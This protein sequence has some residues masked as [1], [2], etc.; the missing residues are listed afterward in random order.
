MY[1]HNAYMAY[2]HP[3]IK[4]LTR[5][6][7]MW[8]LEKERQRSK[9]AVWEKEKIRKA[10]PEVLEH[11][12]WL[13]SIAHMVHY[14]KG[15]HSQLCQECQNWHAQTRLTIGLLEINE[16]T[17]PVGAKLRVFDVKKLCPYTWVANAFTH[18][19]LTSIVHWYLKQ[20]LA[21]K[22]SPVL[23]T[24]FSLLNRWERT[25]PSPAVPAPFTRVVGGEKSRIRWGFT[26][27]KMSTGLQP[28]SMLS[29]YL[30]S[31][32]L[33]GKRHYCFAT[34]RVIYGISSQFLFKNSCG[35]NEFKITLR[36]RHI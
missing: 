11:Q 17:A 25:D 36:F 19:L 9:N 21:R 2:I 27:T 34:Q 28:S 18:L 29:K 22:P 14:D 30:T 24:R 10:W 4:T 20:L 13:P 23:S 7:Q 15:P 33:P 31:L 26:C 8:E 5:W 16:S 12:A 35:D 6:K 1:I 32:S 3:V